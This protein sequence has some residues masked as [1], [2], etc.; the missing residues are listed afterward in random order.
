MLGYRPMQVRWLRHER[1][2][3]IAVEWVKRSEPSNYLPIY[4]SGASPDDL[5]WAQ[6]TDLDPLDDDAAAMIAERFI[7]AQC[8]SQE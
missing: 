3:T 5:R 8:Y 6:L 7:A 2:Y 1:P 4:R